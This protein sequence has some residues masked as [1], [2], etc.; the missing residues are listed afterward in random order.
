[1][2]VETVRL[3]GGV[4]QL[5]ENVVVAVLP[6]GTLTVREVPPLTVQFV[7]TPAIATVWLPAARFV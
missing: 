3:P 1:V 4:V 6:E 7:A 5:T 2:L